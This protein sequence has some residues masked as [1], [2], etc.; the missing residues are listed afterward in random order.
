MAS[1][2]NQ[3]FK[4][5]EAFASKE[6]SSAD[7][8][9]KLLR[10]M[11]SLMGTEA[12][13]STTA[14]VA[15]AP[16]PTPAPEQTAPA[17]EP[18]SAPEEAARA[19]DLFE[20]ATNTAPV[21]TETPAPKKRRAPRKPKA[22]TAPEATQPVEDAP[23]T[24]KKRST[25]KAE[26]TV[27]NLQPA[28]LEEGEPEVQG[29]DEVQVEMPDGPPALPIEDALTDDE[30]FCLECGRGMTMLK[31]HLGSAH[32]LTPEQYRKRW[33]LPDDYPVTAPNY[34]VSKSD[35]AKKIQFGQKD[36][37]Y[38]PKRRGRKKKNAA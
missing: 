26:A 5:A 33:D 23:K 34:S 31:R 35:Y 6:S 22:E 36:S 3:W 25:T 18:Q 28:V 1:D 10:E 37:K 14:P 17:V 30:I 27:E 29:T 24:R 32:N 20:E 21:A 2:D 16:A 15:E 38:A 8:V 7:D 4:I 11:K 19:A 9:V 13:T 12:P